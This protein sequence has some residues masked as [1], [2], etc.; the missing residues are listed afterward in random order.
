MCCRFRYAGLAA[1]R[2]RACRFALSPF[3]LEVVDVVQYRFGARRQRQ[4]LRFYAVTIPRS[5]LL[6]ARGPYE[7]GAMYCTRSAGFLGAVTVLPTFLQYVR[8]R[9]AP[10]VGIPTVDYSVEELLCLRDRWSAFFVRH[11]IY[12]IRDKCRCESLH[13]SSSR[14]SPLSARRSL[15]GQFQSRKGFGLVAERRVTS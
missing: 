9:A 8:T 6:S 2:L 1:V 5:T 13:S 4:A 14:L 3:R 10:R 12:Q 7:G 15:C 11:S